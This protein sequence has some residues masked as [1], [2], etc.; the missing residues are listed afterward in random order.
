MKLHGKIVFSSG[1]ATD[2]D[3]WCLNLGT[4]SLRQLTTG[5]DLNEF[6]RWSPDGKK[7][8][9]ISTGNDLIRS[10]HVMNADGSDRKR[11]TDKVHCQFPSWSPDGNSIFFTANAQDP[12]DIDICRY[13]LRNGKYEV[14]LRRQ[15]EESAPTCSPDGRSLLF[16][17]PTDDAS[18]PFAHR[19]TDIWE[20]D[21]ATKSLSKLFKHPAKDYDPVYSPDGTKVAF[22]SQRN[23]YSEEEYATA[24]AAIRAALDTRDRDSVDNAIAQ[25]RE[26]EA[27]TDVYV[28]NRD[29]TDLRKLTSNE[30]SDLGVRWSP[31]GN[32]LVYSASPKGEGAAERLRIV[33]VST[34]NDVPLEYDRD[35]FMSEIG[36]APN[37]FFNDRLFWHFVPD[38]IERPF[39]MHFVGASFWGEEHHPDWTYA[40]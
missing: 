15:G 18:G 32:F 3:I 7:I 20:L 37:Q 24:L 29:G 5:Q 19:D 17:A 31:C 23:E 39:R 12:N 40:E 21:L 4:G 14:V 28:A 8:V 16:A 22:I 10:L 36:A 9:F 35:P 26:L 30:G 34:G 27:D 1:R 6:P 13:D 2:Y 38:F 11:L 33:E 25:L